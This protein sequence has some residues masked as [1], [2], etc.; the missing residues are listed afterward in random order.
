MRL[1]NVRSFYA[2]YAN[3][4]KRSSASTN[5]LDRWIFS[6]LQEL[7]RDTTLGFDTYELDVAARPL[8]AFIDDLSTWYLR[9]SRDRFKEAGEDKLQALA[10]LRCVLYMTAQV[11]APIMPFFAESLFQAVKEDADP[12]SVH[13]CG[14]PATG[15]IDTQLIADMS[16]IRELASR[17]LEA[18]DKAGIKVRQPLA[19]LVVQSVPRDAQLQSILADEIN[20]KEVSEDTSLD[21]EVSLDTMLTP[22]L[23]AEGLM[24]GFVRHIQAW[25]K[26][27][28]LTISDRPSFT[29]LVASADEKEIAEKYRKEIMHET[30]LKELDISVQ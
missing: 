12:E 7:V 16:R 10:T 2:L 14:W 18:R 19:R 21:G 15:A 22:E 3:D 6:R 29:L 20:V 27:Q 26:E 28:N 11:M 1:D 17:G 5:V 4:T 30:G 9:R 25:R 13:L 8:A 24:R 23:K